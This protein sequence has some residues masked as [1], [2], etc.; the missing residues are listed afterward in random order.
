MTG[1]VR[2]VF[3]QFSLTLTGFST[4][5]SFSLC[6]VYVGCNFWIDS[7]IDFWTNSDSKKTE[8]SLILPSSTQKL[9]VGVFSVQILYV[10]KVYLLTC[11]ESK[12]I[13]FNFFMTK[14]NY[15]I[16]YFNWS[17]MGIRF[18]KITGFDCC[19]LISQI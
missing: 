19:C 10:C 5:T 3:H 4:G 6:V 16:V 2:T 13:A 15:N 7:H 18:F 9:W 11:I 1:S 17:W 14:K 8:K 12:S